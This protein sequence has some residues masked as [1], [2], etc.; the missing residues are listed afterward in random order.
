VILYLRHAQASSVADEQTLNA[1]WRVVA[2]PAP[3]F[4]ALDGSRPAAGRSARDLLN[5]IHGV[6]LSLLPDHF[7]F[8]L[9]GLAQISRCA[10]KSGLFYAAATKKLV[11]IDGGYNAMRHITAPRTSLLQDLVLYKLGNH[12]CLAP[13]SLDPP[14][15]LA[16]CGNMVH[17]GTDEDMFT[18]FE[19]P[20][21]AGLYREVSVD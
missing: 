2:D 17:A 4:L 18:T 6:A 13:S 3:C 10:R 8:H 1:L 20:C 21:I 9:Q 11:K 12:T 5:D 15:A 19:A 14:H 16:Q 7:Q